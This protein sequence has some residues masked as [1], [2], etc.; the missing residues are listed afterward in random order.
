MQKALTIAESIPGLEGVLIL[1]Q[2]TMAAWGN[3]EL[4]SL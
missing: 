2:D 1:I 4:V 3:L